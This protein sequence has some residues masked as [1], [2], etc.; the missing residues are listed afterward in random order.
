M[1]GQAYG[2][3][4][5]WFL[6]KE[7]L[8]TGRKAEALDDE[9]AEIADTPVWNICNDTK[10]EHSPDLPVQQFLPDLIRLVSLVFHSRLIVPQTHYRQSLFLVQE[11][12]RGHGRVWEEGDDNQSPY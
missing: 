3:I 8:L 10:D 12:P 11:V 5:E 9:C 4:S 2:R 6:G 7:K 1:I